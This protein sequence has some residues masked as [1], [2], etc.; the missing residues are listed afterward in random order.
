M[1]VLKDFFPDFTSKIIDVRNY[2]LEFS[3]TEHFQKNWPIFTQ[4]CHFKLNLSFSFLEMLKCAKMS[5]N[6]N[7]SC[8]SILRTGLINVKLGLKIWVKQVKSIS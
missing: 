7:N 4:N 1:V 3:K 2:S 6:S 8:L 5:Q